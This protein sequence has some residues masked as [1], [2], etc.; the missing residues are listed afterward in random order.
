MEDG[1]YRIETTRFV[2]GFYVENGEVVECAPILRK[3]LDYWKK[4]IM[5]IKVTNVEVEKINKGKT[6]YEIAN[7][8]YQQNGE[9]KSFKVFSFKNPQVFSDIQKVEDG[10]VID[11]SS[12]KGDDGYFQW[13]KITRGVTE[14]KTPQPAAGGKVLG[15][16]YETKE[17][18][19]IKQ[20]YI[21]KQSSLTAALKYIELAGINPENNQEVLA[22]AQQFTDWVLGN[23][24]QEVDPT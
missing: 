20:V 24:T 19:A 9:P 6:K 16:N 3:R 8:S 15:S 1:L 18:R 23:D 21:I 7:V 17:E 4:L 2:A 11:V 10:E 14:D 13:T 5:Q 12:V 22:L